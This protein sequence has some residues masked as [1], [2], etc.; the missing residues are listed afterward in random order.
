M[1]AA[2]S[3]SVDF[4]DRQQDACDFSVGT[5]NGSGWGIDVSNLLSPGLFTGQSVDVSEIAIVPMLSFG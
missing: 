5:C 4:E 3:M 1:L 2:Q